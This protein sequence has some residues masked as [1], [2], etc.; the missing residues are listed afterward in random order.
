M[1]VHDSQAYRKMGVA[2]K[3][4]SGWSSPS[5]MTDENLKSKSSL[6]V[7]VGQVRQQNHWSLLDLKMPPAIGP[8]LE[9]L[10]STDFISD[11]DP[12]VSST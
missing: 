6:A 1:R 11:L 9:S 5:S 10:F 12:L 4:I 7:T 8:D 3:R 2:R